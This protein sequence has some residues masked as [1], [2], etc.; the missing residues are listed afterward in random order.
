M[1]IRRL[2]EL[3]VFGLV[4]VLCLAALWLTHIVPAEF[5]DA[6]AVYQGF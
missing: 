5:L 1:T 4:V 6:H 3:L 2:T